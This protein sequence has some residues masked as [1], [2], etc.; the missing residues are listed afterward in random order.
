MITLTRRW[1]RSRCIH[2]FWLI[3]SHLQPPF[4]IIYLEPKPGFSTIWGMYNLFN[5]MSCLQFVNV[6]LLCQ[7]VPSQAAP[8]SPNQIKIVCKFLQSNSN[9]PVAVK[10]CLLIA[11]VSFLRGSNM[12][13]PT[14]TSWGGPH[15]LQANDII[16]Y[17]DIIVIK[18][19]SSKTSTGPRPKFIE[20]FPTSDPICCP[21]QAW[22]DYT[23]K[24][25]PRPLGP[26][27]ITDAGLP[28]TTGP[29]VLAIRL[30]LTAAGH[31][32][33]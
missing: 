1:Q 16:K 14:L 8:L 26:A 11:Y 17:G 28:L 27:F 32:A 30:A 6:L 15:T 19:S 20:I 10:P 2:N 29:V 33:S 31:P 21:V 12:V 5:P 23:W 13:S 7:I 3:L 18:V 4:E 24:I 22:D 25:N 9:F